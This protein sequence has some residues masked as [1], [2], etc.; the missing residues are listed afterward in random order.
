MAETP[1]VQPAFPNRLSIAVLPFQNMSGD[2][3]QEYFADGISEISSPRYL[4]FRSFSSSRATPASPSKARILMSGMS[5]R[6]WVSA[7][8]WREASEIGNRVRITSQ[9]IEASPADIS[10]QNV[11]IGTSRTSSR[12][13]T[14]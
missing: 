1:A 5:A 2:P 14:T 10:G 4:S 11:L 7:M 6:N 3:E 8:S 13:R 12:S 9:L